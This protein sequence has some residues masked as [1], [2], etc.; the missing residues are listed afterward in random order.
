MQI[1]R[2]L[3]TL[4]SYSQP[5][6]AVYKNQQRPTVRE[7]MDPSLFEPRIAI[8][9]SIRDFTA[10]RAAVGPGPTLGTDFHT[11]LSVA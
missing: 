6:A 5:T 2:P 4:D 10:V 11:R 7:G 8:A 1:M 3:L 9:N